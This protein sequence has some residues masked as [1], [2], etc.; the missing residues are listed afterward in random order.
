METTS[1]SLGSQSPRSALTRPIR[2]SPARGLEASA[3]PTV[4][5]HEDLSASGLA[6]PF[7]PE[8]KCAFSAKRSNAFCHLDT[9]HARS[10]HPHRRPTTSVSTTFAL[11]REYL[12]SSVVRK[13][14]TSEA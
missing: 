5:S 14:E 13:D 11:R 4:G 12:V 10:R 3:S 7:K 1:S 9:R 2:A 8:P 6:S